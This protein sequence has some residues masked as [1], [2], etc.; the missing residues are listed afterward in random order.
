M[1]ELKVTL[2]KLLKYTNENKLFQV[3]QNGSELNLV[4][5]PNFPEAEAHSRGEPVR[6]IMKGKV[7]EDKVVFEKIYVDEST[8]YYEKDMEEAVHAYS[9]WLEFI[10]ENY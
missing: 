8:S 3:S 1:Q 7:K 2:S 10:E 4:F 5:V 9:A 6:I